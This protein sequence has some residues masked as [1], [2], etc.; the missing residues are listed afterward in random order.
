[1][2]PKTKFDYINTDTD[3]VVFIQGGNDLICRAMT[4]HPEVTSDMIVTGGSDYEWDKWA[5]EKYWNKI[6]KKD[7]IDLCEK[8]KSRNI[9]FAILFVRGDWEREYN[10]TEKKFY[11]M[12]HNAYIEDY[13][14]AKFTELMWIWNKYSAI[15]VRDVDLCGLP[16]ED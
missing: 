16:L 15:P 1:M 14:S 2:G 11:E 6:V 8:L 10:A 3:L 7:V 9:K 13:N 12:S 5:R 4:T